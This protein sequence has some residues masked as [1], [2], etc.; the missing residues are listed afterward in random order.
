MIYAK[1]L[2]VI[3]YCTKICRNYLMLLNSASDKELILFLRI[4]HC[5]LLSH[6]VLIIFAALG[7]IAFE[8]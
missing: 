7:A 4:C 2:L 3:Y 6:M 5:Y 1:Y 8:G